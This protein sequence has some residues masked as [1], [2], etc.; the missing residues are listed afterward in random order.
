V[1][2]EEA[3]AKKTWEVIVIILG[4]ALE[5]VILIKDTLKGG[6]HDSSSRSPKT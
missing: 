4:I 1:E 3:M 6:K 2:A 5:I